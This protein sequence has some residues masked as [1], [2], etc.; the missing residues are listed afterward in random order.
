[1]SGSTEAKVT[2]WLQAWRDGDNEALKA[3]INA[4]YGQ[5]HRLAAQHMRTEHAGHSLQPTGLVHE[6]Y[7]RLLGQQ[8]VNW[9][10]RAHFFAIAARQMRRILVDHARRLAASK[11]D[12]R[13]RHDLPLTLHRGEPPRV[14]LVDLEQA[15]QNLE[16]KDKG[17]CD[18][19]ELRYFGGLT[20][21]ETAEVLDISATKVKDDWLLAKAW[22]AKQLANRA[23]FPVVPSH[24]NPAVTPT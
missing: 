17:L 9:R 3:L 21:K 4:I 23:G 14:D 22:L 1:M 8:K 12:W 13:L 15:L 6:V 18:L 11:R 19:V 2:E 10:N 16:R 5:L 24:E 7:L 20:I